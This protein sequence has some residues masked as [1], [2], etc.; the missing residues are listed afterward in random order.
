MS[1][2]SQKNSFVRQPQVPHPDLLNFLLCHFGKNFCEEWKSSCSKIKSR[3]HGIIYIHTQV[4][5][6]ECASHAATLPKFRDGSLIWRL[7]QSPSVFSRWRIPGWRG[8]FSPTN[9]C[10][11]KEYLN[12]KPDFIL[13]PNRSSVYTTLNDER[14]C[15]P[16]SPAAIYIGTETYLGTCNN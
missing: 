8:K 13:D 11:V 4:C 12:S 14:A 2:K 15:T 10:I 6:L 1:T 5:V 7:I 3:G 16:M 9:S